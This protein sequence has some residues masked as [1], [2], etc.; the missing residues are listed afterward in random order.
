MRRV[1]KL[2]LGLSLAVGSAAAGDL[3]YVTCQ[4]GDAL[5][6]HDLSSGATVREWSVPGKPAGIALTK[7][8]A[9]TVSPDSKTLRRFATNTGDVLAMTE[10]DG[11]PIGVALD[12]TRQRLFVSDWYNARIWI[13]AADTLALQGE[14]TVGAA[15]AGLAVSDDGNFIAA[16]E[17]DE[18]QV[19]VFDA[20]TLELLHTVPVGIRPFGLRFAPDGRLFVGNV[21]SND[22]S[23]IDPGDSKV[24]ATVPVGERPY[25]IAFANERAFVTN[26]YE[27]TLSVVDLK[28]LVVIDTIDTGDYP[29]GIDTSS[30]G[31]QIIVANWFDNS[32]TIVDAESHSVLKTLETCDG[33]RAFGEFVLGGEP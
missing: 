8:S 28:T 12:A 10:L 24:I 33:P 7:G 16:A 26:Q 11:G 31:R 15:P 3:A 19:A 21:G 14:L 17:R 5:F 27:N 25:G 2:A 30:D 6:V 18:D 23:V 1:R 9:Y 13:L 4:N 20:E 29:E 32:L 22:L